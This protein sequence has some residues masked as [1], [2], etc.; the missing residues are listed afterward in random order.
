MNA[1]E[2]F[3][4]LYAV[5]NPEQMKAC[6]ESQFRNIQVETPAQQYMFLKLNRDHA[7]RIAQ[8]W[9]AKHYGAGYVV[10]INVSEAYL[11]RCERM[12]IAYAEHEEYRVCAS[13]L[14]SLHWYMGG[15]VSVMTVYWDPKY[16]KID[17]I[18]SFG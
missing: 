16:R 1:N 12:S 6:K 8:E 7:E 4:E 17:E 3:T 9:T 15:R 10:R 18:V 13:E 5:L 2:T 11:E 14:S